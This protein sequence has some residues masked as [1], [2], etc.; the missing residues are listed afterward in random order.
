MW[1]SSSS[2][3]LAPSSALSFIAARCLF[4]DRGG[5]QA[6]PPH[7]RG[8]RTQGR[9]NS[10]RDSAR[11]ERTN[12]PPVLFGE[13]AAGPA[14]AL[15]ELERDGVRQWHPKSDNSDPEQTTAPSGCSLP[16]PRRL[17]TLSP[18][19][20]RRILGARVAERCFA[21]PRHRAKG[22]RCHP[23]AAT[24]SAF[25]G[26][27]LSCACNAIGSKPAIAR[28]SG[29]PAR[30]SGAPRRA[31]PRT[32]PRPRRASQRTTDAMSGARRAGGSP[33]PPLRAASLR[34]ATETA[35]AHERERAGSLNRERCLS[36]ARAG[37]VSP[38][39]TG[40]N[41]RDRPPP[42]CAPSPRKASGR[43]NGRAAPS[44]N[45]NG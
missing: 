4:H 30:R 37:T 27:Q 35:A 19:A 15:F 39:W 38:Q 22:L 21:L 42:G 41:L 10:S 7:D 17:L 8:E 16:P 5:S 1:S 18:I 23:S 33:A 26:G 24:P 25:E 31:S 32:N 13:T 29:S 3:S 34:M 12:S 44:M 6:R 14:R 28:R 40:K 20:R 2:N 36:S 45:R 9:R 43:Y 11:S